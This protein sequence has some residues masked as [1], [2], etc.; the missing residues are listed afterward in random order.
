MIY[1]R[2]ITKDYLLVKIS[3]IIDFSFVYEKVKNGHSAI[4]R[5]SK[6]PDMISKTCLLK[7]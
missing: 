2:L 3:S 4:G 6:D 5:A 1:D 7:Y